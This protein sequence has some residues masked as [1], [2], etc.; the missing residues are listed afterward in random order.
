MCLDS[1]KCIKKRGWSQDLTLSNLNSMM[2]VFKGK[3][4]FKPEKKYVP[5]RTYRFAPECPT[6]STKGHVFVSGS[7]NH[8]ED[9]MVAQ[10]GLPTE[11]YLTSAP[12]PDCAMMLYKTYHNYRRSQPYTSVGMYSGCDYLLS[13]K[14]C[15]CAF[16]YCHPYFILQFIQLFLHLLNLYQ[17]PILVL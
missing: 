12:H 4:W 10:C 7:G 3:A 16:W 11:F 17:G 1:T 6:L 2:T 8:T 14:S 13:L 15:L 5:S 9:D